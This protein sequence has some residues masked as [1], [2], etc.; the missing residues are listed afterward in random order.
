MESIDSSSI[1]LHLTTATPTVQLP[2]LP[3]PS[4]AV[5][6]N[7]TTTASSSSTPSI[8][9]LV[10]EPDTEE[11]TTPS[12][13]ASLLKQI[14]LMKYELTLLI[15]SFQQIS[16]QLVGYEHAARYTHL[17]TEIFIVE[18]HK[19]RFSP[20]FPT[21]KQTILCAKSTKA[22]E[23]TFL[24]VGRSPSESKRLAIT[25]QTFVAKCEKCQRHA[26]FIH[27]PTELLRTA[28]QPYPFMRWAMDIVGPLPASR[29]K[30]YILI[31]TD[32]FTKWV[33][34]ESYAK[35]QSKEVQNFV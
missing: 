24:A 14:G 25:G 4:P 20:V 21:A 35:I 12:A 13:P 5:I 32:Y 6:A 7:N 8:I 27:T 17:L 16:G 23:E 15:S 22:Q 3:T 19:E 18:M 9:L 11:S 33:E 26:P 34:A 2:T 31:M 1:D 10:V 29:Q 30:K 28:S